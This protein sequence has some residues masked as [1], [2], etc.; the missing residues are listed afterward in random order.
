MYCICFRF[1]WSQTIFYGDTVSFIEQF[2]QDGLLNIC[3][4]FA[5]VFI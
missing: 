2:Y 4:G 1:F 3:G 5:P